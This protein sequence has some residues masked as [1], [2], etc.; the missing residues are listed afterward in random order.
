MR[1]LITALDTNKLSSRR[2]FWLL[3]SLAFSASFA[4]EVVRVAFS[5]EY[6]ITDDAR[7]HVFW[8][9]RFVVPELFPNDLIANFYQSVSP[10]GFSSFYK[11]MATVGIDPLLLNKILP[12]PLALITTG[13]CFAACVEI[14]PVPA[15]GFVASLLL[16]HR[17]WLGS[18]LTTAAPTSFL[19]P[20]FIAFLY[21]LLRR[22]WLG[23]GL[24]MALIGTF[25]A[26]LMLVAA[27]MLVVRLVGGKIL[28]VSFSHN[29]SDYIICAV[30][31]G[32]AL[33]VILP[34]LIQSSE[35]GPAIAA[36]EA[37][38]LP[39]FLPGG[40]TEF[41][42][43]HRPWKFWFQGS[44]SGIRLS[45]NPPLV[46]LGL[47]LPILLKFPSRF[48]LAKQV[49]TEVIILLELLISSLTLFFAAHVLL[50]KLF[51]PSRYTVH[52]LR[53]GMSIAAGVALILILDGIF[54]ACSQRI[55]IPAGVTVAIAILLVFYPSL[56]WSNSFPRA[57]FIVGTQPALYQFFQQ[58]P[59]DTLIASL[60]YEADNLP[61]FA[62]RSVLVSWEYALPYQVGYYSNLRQRAIDLIRAQYSSDI[63]L[64]R[65]FI[66]TYG[67][68]FF[69]LDRAAFTPEYLNRLTWFRQWQNLK[70]EALANLNGDSSLVMLSS[71]KRCSAIE[72][73]N[74]IVL[75][76]KCVARSPE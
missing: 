28:P 1:K 30:G 47:L 5:S 21:Y 51:L 32:V 62:Q 52:S 43:D 36:A 4:L 45:F 3:L 39:E 72:N 20:T 26:P 16:N 10:A 34:Y 60:S 66:N 44:R 37:R 33:L 42:Y 76:A 31:I 14:L 41:F 24:S 7:Q 75:E 74:F 40:R 53:I 13:F 67:I 9:Q 57:S 59:P 35:Y 50:F 54:Q 46:V 69:L 71:L 27:G 65:D 23:V 22:S 70:S 29:R 17:L 15:A 56:F 73:D 8:M 49:S 58:Q 11:L 19:Y 12:I 25:Y 6:L 38:K 18:D 63:N 48:P 68:D 61:T 64:V 55:L 2:I